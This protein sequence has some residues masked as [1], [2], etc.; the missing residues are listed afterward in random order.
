MGG[1]TEC[2]GIY[3]LKVVDNFKI[4]IFVAEYEI[5]IPT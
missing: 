3:C 2:Y 1:G 5:H 4:A